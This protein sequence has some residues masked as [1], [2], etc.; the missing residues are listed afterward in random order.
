LKP[1]DY[2]LA[3]WLAVVKWPLT[4]FMDAFVLRGT[5]RRAAAE[6][7]A[8]ATK[9]AG[10]P[11][12]VARAAAER[13]TYANDPWGG[14][15]DYVAAPAVTWARRRG[16]CDDFAYLSAELLRRAGV[17][18]WLASY[19][20]WNVNRSHVVCLFR[21]GNAYAVMDQGLIRGPFKTLADAAD[22]GNPGAKNAARY[23]RRYGCG[24]DFV[25]KR[26]AK[27]S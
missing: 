13:V 24:P 26:F 14:L 10:G 12:A 22:A 7:D 1:L 20:C 25:G 19:F 16:D 17:E 27:I 3:I 18:S 5:R 9:V 23:V 2:I 6:F 21:D 11:A 8:W 15:L 4:L